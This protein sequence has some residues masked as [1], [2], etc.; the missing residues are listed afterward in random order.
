MKIS[1]KKAT[2]LLKSL[3]KDVE[4]VD[5][6][7]VDTDLDIDTFK[8]EIEAGIKESYKPILA[9]ELEPTVQ[10]KLQKTFGDLERKSVFKAFGITNKKEYENLGLEEM[11]LKAKENLQSQ[12][13]YKEDEWNQK[14]KELTAQNEQWEEK[15]N[16]D[17]ARVNSEW[18]EKYEGRDVDANLLGIFEKIPRKEGS[19][20]KHIQMYKA[21]VSQRG[22]KLKP[23]QD[24]KK[25]DFYKDNQL[26]VDNGK[27]M[28]ISKDATNWAKEMGILAENTAHIPP[29][30]VQQSNQQ[31]QRR[32][33]PNASGKNAD[34]WS[35]WAKMAES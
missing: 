10:S 19:L 33:Y 4:L 24:G 26:H 35:G 12:S 3:G 25:V 18:Q 7:S 13:G 22:L 16:N 8:D 20:Q 5:D 31:N 2:Q 34:P 11:L 28:D 14:Y 23:N 1:L 9:Q 27:T 21:D 15:Y 32:D 6:D 29:A 17:L 30:A